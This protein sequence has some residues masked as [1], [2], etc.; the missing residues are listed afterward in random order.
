MAESHLIVI[1]A[2]RAGKKYIVKQLFPAIVFERDGNSGLSVMAS[3]NTKYYSAQLKISI[4]QSGQVNSV[5]ANGCEILMLVIDQT[6]RSDVDIT[7]WSRKVHAACILVVYNQPSE[8]NESEDFGECII[9][10]LSKE[11]PDTI[12]EGIRISYN[13]C[14]PDI[15]SP[16]LLKSDGTVEGLYRKSGIPAF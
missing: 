9:P 5:D 7:A 4:F 13:K 1:G 15:T 8:T 10:S 3:L 6:S 11:F 12:I 2:P 14:L 16:G